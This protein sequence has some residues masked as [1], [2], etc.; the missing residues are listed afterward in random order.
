MHA[1]KLIAMIYAARLSLPDCGGSRRVLQAF[2]I[3]TNLG[4]DR[5]HGTPEDM[6]QEDNIPLQVA[7]SVQ[8][9]LLVGTRAPF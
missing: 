4:G 1:G 5:Q 6:F 7:A 2:S 9:P 3:G 8:T